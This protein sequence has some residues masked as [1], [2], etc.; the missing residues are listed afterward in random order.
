M[1]NIAS[2][3][4]SSFKGAKSSSHSKQTAPKPNQQNSSKLSA[5]PTPVRP[6]TDASKEPAT[7]AEILRSKIRKEPEPIEDEG[8]DNNEGDAEGENPTE[9]VIEALPKKKKI[10]APRIKKFKLTPHY[11]SGRLPD[12]YRG[13]RKLKLKGEKGSEVGRNFVKRTYLIFIFSRRICKPS[14]RNTRNGRMLSISR[15]H[16]KRSFPRLK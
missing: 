4:S 10:T 8:A 12:V 13:F 6:K 5:N 2:T 7:T 1:S 15:C 14:L 16:L 9:G 3:S 11:V